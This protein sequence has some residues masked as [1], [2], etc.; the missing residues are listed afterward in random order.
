MEKFIKIIADM[1]G[2]IYIS[3]N[4][5]WPTLND[6]GY[7]LSKEWELSPEETNKTMNDQ[8]LIGLINS[9][10]K[11][12]FIDR[13]KLPHDYYAN[14]YLYNI[15]EIRKNDLAV[16]FFNGK[17]K[18]FYKEEELT[19]ATGITFFFTNNNKTY[20]Y[21]DAIWDYSIISPYQIRATSEWP[22]LGIKQVIFVS[23]DLNKKDTINISI[24]LES[25]QDMKLDHWQICSLLSKLYKEWVG[26]SSQ[27]ISVF[28]S[29]YRY[30]Q[31][32]SRHAAFSIVGIKTHIENSLPAALF[33]CSNN[34]DNTVSTGLSNIGYYYN[35]ARCVSV[36]SNSEIELEKGNPKRCLDM[37]ITLMSN[38]ELD[39]IVQKE[40]F[41]R[42]K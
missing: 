26:S 5:T 24:T 18:I 33:V 36:D 14:I 21:A 30:K 34:I 28:S 13:I 42:E 17:I 37:D 10:K 27:G 6:K 35:N 29:P 11:F 12:S 15:P 9:R 4:N 39:D 22:D 8:R 20:T 2:I 41:A 1:Q 23:L 40:R 32:N 25:Q 3:K 19:K 7:F 31:V 16:K 38:H